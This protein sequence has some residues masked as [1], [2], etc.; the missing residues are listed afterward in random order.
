MNSVAATSWQYI[1]YV[2][3]VR[4]DRDQDYIDSVVY[5]ESDAESSDEELLDVSLQSAL[6]EEPL[7]HDLLLDR[8]EVQDGQQIASGD[9][10]LSLA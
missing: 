8:Q 7:E 3:G 2:G 10:L 1:Q 9:L 6:A 5:T 4:E